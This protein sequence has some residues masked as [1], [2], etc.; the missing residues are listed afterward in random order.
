MRR[1]KTKPA[2]IEKPPSALD[3]PE[4][5]HDA[6]PPQPA[7]SAPAVSTEVHDEAIAEAVKNIHG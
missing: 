2:E 6:S 3:A 1:E 4:S 7:K 5:E